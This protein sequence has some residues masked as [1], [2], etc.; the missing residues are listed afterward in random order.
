MK[1]LYAIIMILCLC[2]SGCG[3]TQNKAM[4]AGLTIDDSETH[5]QEEI[6]T[7]LK[8][9]HVKPMVRMVFSKNRKAASYLSFVKKVSK[10]ASI[11]AC[12]YDSSY[13]KGTTLTHHHQRYLDYIRL[14]KPYV[15]LWEIG[16]EVNGNWLGSQTLMSQ[17]ISDTYALCQ[18]YHLKTALTA[19]QCRPGDQKSSMNIWLKKYISATIR[20]HLDYVWVSYYDDDND[21]Y[22]YQWKKVFSEL[23]QLFPFSKLGFGECGFSKPHRYDQTWIK[24][25]KAYYYQKRYAAYY[26]GGCFWWNW[27]N[28]CVPY[29]K[30]SFRAMD[31]ACQYLK[32]Q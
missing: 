10:V 14:L 30:A 23:H 24:R 8:H 15:T 20:Q 16:N 19:Y 6:L 28:D 27:S 17:K 3:T 32:K 22:H 2:L 31:R 21:G 9:M 1:K 29:Q 4:I 18:T 25:L 12:V 5:S 11:M 26:V 13:E 7:A